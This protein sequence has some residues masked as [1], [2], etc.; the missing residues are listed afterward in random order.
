MALSTTPVAGTL[1]RE[2]SRAGPLLIE[3]ALII[4]AIAAMLPWFGA[5]R[6]Q[7]TGN[8]G[9]FADA[10]V[11]VHGLPASV[12]PD[13]CAAYA[14]QASDAVRERLCGR[15]ASAQ[16]N[17]PLERV[18]QTLRNAALRTVQAFVSP[19]RNAQARLADLRQ[20]EGGGDRSM[21]GDEVVRVSAEIQ[22]FIDRYALG[23]GD[24]DGPRPLACSLAQLQSLF[25]DSGARQQLRANVV[26]L[27]AAALDSHP[28]VASLARGAGLPS[29]RS[30]LSRCT[31][32]RLPDALAALSVTMA[33]ARA[34]ALGSAKSEAMRAL[35]ETAG[36][37]WAGC[38]RGC[39]C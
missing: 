22:T 21:I 25:A 11:V 8:D 24:G 9:R 35:L 17:M 34:A 33:D 3:F 10:A 5:L 29:A 12:L 37:Q 16:R 30:T 28:D 36:F 39:S 14:A 18:P 6:Q 32:V 7:Q 4:A 15:T 20:R 26:L 13:L 31:G 27:A 23:P 1:S 38:W 19:L 2:G